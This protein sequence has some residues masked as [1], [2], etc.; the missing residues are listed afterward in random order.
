MP[1]IVPPAAKRELAFPGTVARGASG[2]KVRRVQEW[3]CFHDFATTIDGG[4]G[5][6]TTDAVIRFQRARQLESTGDVD[7]ET[8]SELV[9][10]LANVL[11][12][13]LPPE[14]GIDAATLAVAQAHLREKPVELGGDNRGPW[15]R[16]YTGGF[17]G[18]EW[19]WCAAFVTFVLQQACGLLDRAKPIAGSA[20]CD[21]LA[22]QAKAKGLFVAGKSVSD[23]E[24]PRPGECQIFLVARTQ[25]DWTHTGF[26]LGSDREVFRT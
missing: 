10:P 15:V 16:T 4:F 18:V 9:A 2:A 24:T 21:S 3:L 12:I 26:A 13:S 6:A 22:Y 17:D 23:G 5:P 14:L 20:S 7:G 11:G 8:W 19:R 1:F 25:S